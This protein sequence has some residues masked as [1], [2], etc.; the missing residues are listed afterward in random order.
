MCL[1]V[2]ER[3]TQKFARI[4]QQ[5]RGQN[6]IT[7][8]HRGQVDII[9]WPVIES[10]QFYGLFEVLKDRFIK[11]PTTHHHAVQFVD[12]LKTLMAKLKV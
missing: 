9:P 1:T 2:F 3:F 10:S 5:E 12:V 6:F 11:R 8:L 7:K 4:V